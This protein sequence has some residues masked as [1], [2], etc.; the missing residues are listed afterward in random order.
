MGL[1]ASDAELL[2]MPCPTPMPSVSMLRSLHTMDW[3]WLWQPVLVCQLCS[4][5]MG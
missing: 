3:C 5:G 1:Q 2:P 4:L